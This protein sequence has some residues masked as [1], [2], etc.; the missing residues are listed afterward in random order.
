MTLDKIMLKD[1]LKGD[2]L[3]KGTG[4]EELDNL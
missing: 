1:W 3:I 2:D 4:K